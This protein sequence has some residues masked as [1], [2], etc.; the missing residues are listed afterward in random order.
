MIL[1]NSGNLLF[2]IERFAP[3]FVDEIAI[4]IIS[5]PIV[6]YPGSG[7]VPNVTM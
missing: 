5:G 1:R 4:I 6:R 2:A 3:F 7:S